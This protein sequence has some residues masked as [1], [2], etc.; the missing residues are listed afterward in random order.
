MK[1]IKTIIGRREKVDL[2]D[3]NLHQIEAKMDTGAYTSALHCQKVKVWNRNGEQFVTFQL[4]DVAH[5]H[6]KNQTFEFPVH[7]TKKI[8][9]SNGITQ[10]RY[11][12]STRMRIGE[13][14][15]NVEFSLADRS[16]MEYPILIGRKAL[17]GKFI[18]DVSKKHILHIL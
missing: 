5:P 6:F 4:L 18:V 17:R 3:F 1:A 10:M 13:F 9:S 15:L 2:P 16:R 14:E 7:K 11:I 12:I 8:K